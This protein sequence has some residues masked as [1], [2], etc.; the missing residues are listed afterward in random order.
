[1]RIDERRLG[2]RGP[3]ALLAA[4]AVLTL[5][6]LAGA[7]GPLDNTANRIAVP[8]TSRAAAIF[9]DADRDLDIDDPGDRDIIRDIVDARVI[10]FA[11]HFAANLDVTQLKKSL[12]RLVDPGMVAAV[13]PTFWD[14]LTGLPQLPTDGTWTDDDTKDLR[15]IR[16]AFM[17]VSMMEFGAPGKFAL[18]EE[19]AGTR[20]GIERFSGE[21]GSD[22]EFLKKIKEYEDGWQRLMIV[23]VLGMPGGA[24]GS[25]DPATTGLAEI[26]SLLGSVQNG[27]PDSVLQTWWAGICNGPLKPASDLWKLNQSWWELNAG[28]DK[29]RARAS[30]LEGGPKPAILSG[31][32]LLSTEVRG[33]TPDS[34]GADDLLEK[35]ST[36]DRWTVKLSFSS[37]PPGITLGAG[38]WAS[39][40]L[41]LVYTPSGTYTVSDTRTDNF[42]CSR[43]EM[44]NEPIDLYM[45]DR[46]YQ[47]AY[48]ETYP[49]DDA[50]PV[51]PARSW[52]HLLDQ[53]LA[54]REKPPT[55]L[56]PTEGGFSGSSHG[57]G[58]QN[59][60][61]S[62]SRG[63]GSSF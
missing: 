25:S 38:T 52:V 19:P 53:L 37:Y 29:V 47:V 33:I 36:A 41:S 45:L 61:F 6:G 26:R 5:A 56:P 17:L 1:M 20:G 50:G 28:S 54:A 9:T 14:A 31:A 58:P 40:G 57:G 21:V 24:E 15:K 16:A 4:A 60:Y 62:S 32:Q 22:P 55:N 23:R 46:S 42:I 2:N 39:Q 13:P 3:L 12:S 27:P 10:Q 49:S 7:A 59:G 34:L 43:I 44:A 48:N 8:M 11:N 51:I 18:F 30:A 35:L 63:L